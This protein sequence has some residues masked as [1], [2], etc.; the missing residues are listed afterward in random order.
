MSAAHTLAGAML[1]AGLGV[2]VLLSFVVAPAA[3][4]LLERPLAVQLMEGVFPAYY[5]AGLV[6]TGL[7]LILVLVLAVGHRGPLRW[8]TAALLAITLGGTLYAGGVLLPQ[9]RAARLRAQAALAGDLA[10]LEFSRLHR[11]A[12][13]V[14][15]ALFATGA[16]ALGLH[17]ASRRP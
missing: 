10:P 14:N 9:A 4:R 8:G 2:Q 15:I 5:G 17:A 16:L 13:A 3:F 11:R 6:T 7:A 12:V 1:G